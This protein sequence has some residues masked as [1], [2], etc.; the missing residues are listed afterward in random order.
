MNV[1]KLKSADEVMVWS[2]RVS[3]GLMHMPEAV[4][5]VLTTTDATPT[6]I[7]TLPIRPTTVYLLEWVALARQS[8]GSGTIGDGAAYQGLVA[9]HL[10]VATA[11]VIGSAASLLAVEDDTN[12]DAAVSFTGNQIE[13]TVT[14]AA[15][16]TI[17]WRIDVTHRTTS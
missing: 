9:A 1:G 3:T 7:L 11:T 12:W 10:V 6:V 8:A 14:G 13:W 2:E 16:K 17:K 5:A 15:S 4:S